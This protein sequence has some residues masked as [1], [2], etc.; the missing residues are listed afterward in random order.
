M[1]ILVDI[2]LDQYLIMIK[3]EHELKSWE[4]LLI[5]EANK[6]DAKHIISYT[7]QVAWESD[8]LSFWAWEYSKTVHDVESIIVQHTEAKN[9]IYLIADVGWHIAWLLNVN[10]SHKTRLSHIWEFG[11]S[12]RSRYHWKWIWSLLMQSMIDWAISTCII[13]KINL[14][15]LADNI[16][17]VKLYQKFWFEIEWTIRRDAFLGWKFSDSY[18][19]WLLID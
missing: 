11:I 5:R 19:M 18:T 4:R 13:R 14:N 2:S 15:V 8:Y 12:V 6:T 10:A 16:S 7:N 9:R 17:A 3:S 1:L